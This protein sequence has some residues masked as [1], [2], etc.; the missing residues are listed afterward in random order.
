[1]VCISMSYCIIRYIN[2][3]FNIYQFLPC[4]IT[5][6]QK[7]HKQTR[8]HPTT[9]SVSE[10]HFGLERDYCSHNKYSLLRY[11]GRPGASPKSEDPSRCHSKTIA[12]A[13]IQDCFATTI[14]QPALR[15]TATI[16]P[17]ASERDGEGGGLRRVTEHSAARRR[18]CDSDSLTH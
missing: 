18:K 7:M 6:S 3:N 4:V 10:H 2:L 15:P 11:H 16:H 14:H 13:T 8:W 17:Q 5:S 1:M 12:R 9:S